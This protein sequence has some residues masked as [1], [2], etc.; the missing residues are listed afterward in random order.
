MLEESP[1]LDPFDEWREVSQAPSVFGPYYSV[2]LDATNGSSFY[3]LATRGTPGMATP[4]DPAT[5]APALAP[6]RFND[7]AASTAFLYTGANAVQTGV[8]TG[9][10]SPVLASVLRGKVKRRDNSPLPG[11]RLALLNHPEFGYTLTRADGR[12]EL[13]V[14]R[15]TICPSC[16]LAQVGAV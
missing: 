9:I 7:H 13:A 10:I 6:N 8:A 5:T 16:S 3:R 1:A 4:P 11:V 2:R 12:F 15:T 14:I